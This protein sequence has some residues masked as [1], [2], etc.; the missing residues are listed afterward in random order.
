MSPNPSLTGGA[1][2]L[3]SDNPHVPFRTSVKA[4]R[5]TWPGGRPLAF[6]VRLDIDLRDSGRPPEWAI[7]DPR[8]AALTSPYFPDHRLFTQHEY[9]ARVG[10]FRVLDV[11]DRHG[12]VPT[13]AVNAA[14]AERYPYLMAMLKE[15]GVEIVGHGT[16]S[17]RMISSKMTEEQE[18]DYIADSLDRLEA[19]TG[20]RAV[21]WA[22]P[23]YGQSY[24]TPALLDAAGIRWMADMP[25]DDMPY[26]TNTPGGLISLPAQNEWDDVE[27]IWHRGLSM[28][29]WRENMVEAFDVLAGE[30]GRVFGMTLRPWLIG[31]PHRI[32]YLDEALARIAPRTDAWHASGGEIAAHAAKQLAAS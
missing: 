31:Q 29:I 1:V 6:W 15:R 8:Q 27:Q 10:V 21:G 17:T 9:G 16:H 25:H 23:D 5:L 13:V 20:K 24:R 3:G 30:Q 18:R 32:R 26:R 28:D 19:V 2:P 7:R 22:S 4:P 12:V 14:A 11:L